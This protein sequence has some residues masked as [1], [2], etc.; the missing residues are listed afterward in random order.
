MNI[1]KCFNSE[2]PPVAVIDQA[3]RLFS[4]QDI[5]DLMVTA[6]YLHECD[7]LVIYRES[8]GEA[9]FDLKSG[10]A[11]E[12]LQKFSDYN[13]KLVVIGDFSH[14]RSQSLQDFIRECNRGNRVFF[15]PSLQAGLE[16]LT[17]L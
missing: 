4:V 12:V 9:F 2:Q 8:L 17:T 6:Q 1:Q 15:K 11:G 16:A 10:Y 7:G 13:M 14:C 5:L 3:T